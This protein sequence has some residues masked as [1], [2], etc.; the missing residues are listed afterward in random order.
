MWCVKN[1]AEQNVNV[2]AL[3][4]KDK[5]YLPHNIPASTTI[6]LIAVHK[7]FIAV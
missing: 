2:L 4:P 5:F 3:K 6:F 7:I 1:F